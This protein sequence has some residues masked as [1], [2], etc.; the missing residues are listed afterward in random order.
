MNLMVIFITVVSG[1]ETPNSNMLNSI[2]MFIF[3]LMFTFVSK[4]L[5]LGKFGLKNQNCLFK[6]KF[7]GTLSNSNMLNSMVMFTFLF[8]TIEIPFLDKFSPKF[9]NG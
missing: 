1:P 5:F 2:V 6:L 9:K 4:L 8:L 7:G 3:A